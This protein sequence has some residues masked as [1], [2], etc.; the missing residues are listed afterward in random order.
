MLSFN[1][2]S[3]FDKCIGKLGITEEVV[4]HIES[5]AISFNRVQSNKAK[6][7]FRSPANK[8]EIWAIR[9]PDPDSNAG[10]SSGFRM[11][12]YIIFDEVEGDSI[13]VDK[14]ERRKNNG[15]RKERPKDQ[16]KYTA[17][18]NR[19]KKELLDTI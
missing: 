11:V 14:T 15:S 3:E 2:T 5:W 17:Y 16:A 7:Y 18:L 10:S 13:F 8:F 9:I 1:R 19:L 4:G 6:L 12:C